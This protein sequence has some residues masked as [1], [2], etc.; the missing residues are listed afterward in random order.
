[1]MALQGH[2][3]RLLL[4]RGESFVIKNIICNSVLNIKSQQQQ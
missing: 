1:M 4:G 2:I 3:Y